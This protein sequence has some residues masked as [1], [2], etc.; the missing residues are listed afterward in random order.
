MQNK[1]KDFFRKISEGTAAVFQKIKTYCQKIRREHLLLGGKIF[2]SLLPPLFLL[3][4]YRYFT[5]EVSDFLPREY[6]LMELFVALTFI[7]SSLRIFYA[8]SKQRWL[9]VVRKVL[10]GVFFLGFPYAVFVLTEWFIHDPFAADPVVMKDNLVL[11]NV[12]FYF[13]L[14]FLLL[15]LTTRT[16][17]AVTLTAGIPMILGIANVLSYA[18][19]SLPIYPWDV[20][21][22]GTAMSVVDNYTFELTSRLAFTIFCFAAIISAGF[23]LGCR[24]KAPKW[25]MQLITAVV[26]VAVFC[27]FCNYLMSDVAEEEEGYYPYLFSANYLYKH[28][29]TAVTFIWTLKYMQLSEPDGYSIANLEMLASSF[30]D[31]AERTS[32]FYDGTRPNVIVIMNEAFCDPAVLGDFETN[33]DYLPFIHSLSENTTKGNV[34]V[35]VKGGNTPNSEFEFLTGT[36]M[37]FLPSGSIPY[38]Q[39]IK[40]D[41]LSLVSQFNDLGYYTVGM[42]PYSASGWQ[43]NEVYPYLGFD[44]TYFSKDFQNKRYVRG[45]VSDETMY[46]QIISIDE[47]T[48]EP[49]FVFGVTMQNHGDYNVKNNG[50][51]TPDVEVLNNNYS[52]ISWLNNYLSLLKVS[53]SAFEKLVS[54][55]E[56]SDEPTIILMFGDHQPNDHVVYP[57]LRA[58]GITD[59]SAMP[60]ETQQT[61]Y[62]TPYILWSN[63]DLESDEHLPSY[64]SLNYLGGYL[65]EA[66]GLPLT[67]F[68]VYLQELRDHYPMIN[69]FC[70]VDENGVWHSNA[71]LQGQELLDLYAQAQYNLIFDRKRLV[72]TF[73]MMCGEL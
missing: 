45:Y 19:R 38:Q 54:Y 63:Y 26:A 67:P 73:F 56:N 7:L 57:V 21:S 48:D 3:W 50:S 20:L 22:A 9:E 13:L 34:L 65:M 27:G 53:D 15:A 72:T 12:V 25:W 58:N 6:F 1:L 33:V 71:E 55:Y 59:I 68:Q 61:R 39:H 8:L 16:D 49:L 69:A 17:V 23:L 62:L 66:A 18:A 35:S 36:S 31:D 60:L 5:S 70:Y 64:T 28:N 43:R 2:L 42:H 32:E 29:G 44:D 52:Y 51:F 37:A 40:G 11:L 24:V 41:T 14:A 30:Y 10:S 4:L 46:D 47:S